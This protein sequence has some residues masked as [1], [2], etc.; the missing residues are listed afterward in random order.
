MI[1][2]GS[3]LAFDGSFSDLICK[4]FLLW[5][6]LHLLFVY[7]WE[8]VFLELHLL[9]SLVLCSIIYVSFCMHFVWDTLTYAI[10]Q[11][12]TSLSNSLSCCSWYLA[13]VMSLHGCSSVSTWHGRLSW[14]MIWLDFFMQTLYD[15]LLWSLDLC[16]TTVPCIQ[17]PP[18]PPCTAMIY[19]WV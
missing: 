5:H 16:S 15:P 11:A 3:V 9:P 17:G 4:P 13:L 12:F 7:F 18:F 2:Y 19:L 10:Y 1:S 8:L 14:L 6:A